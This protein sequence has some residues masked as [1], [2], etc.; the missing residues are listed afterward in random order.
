M[1]WHPWARRTAPYP[2]LFLNGSIPPGN[3]SDSDESPPLIMDSDSDSESDN[4]S[5]GAYAHNRD[6]DVNRNRTRAFTPAFATSP[7][8]PQAPPNPTW[9]QL[10]AGNQN[11]QTPVDKIPTK[12][13][14]PLPRPP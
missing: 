6:D 7:A 10:M 2:R 4:N 11:I 9:S 13:P 3:D 5:V 8:T 1:A 14:R 12:T